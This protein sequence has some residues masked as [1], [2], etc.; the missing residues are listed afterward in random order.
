MP[1]LSPSVTRAWKILS[2]TRIQ[3]FQDKRQQIKNTELM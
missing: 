1:T 3:I 2:E